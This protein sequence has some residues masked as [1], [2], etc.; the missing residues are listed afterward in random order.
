MAQ[1]NYEEVIKPKKGKYKS[2]VPIK[3]SSGEGMFE[4][5]EESSKPIYLPKKKTNV[6]RSN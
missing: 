1:K 2:P 3:L 4:I 5:R 6:I